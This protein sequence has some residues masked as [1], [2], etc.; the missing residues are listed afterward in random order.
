MVVLID[1]KKVSMRIR[2]EIKKEVV[3]LKEKGINP[4]LS[5]VLVGSDMASR[6]YVNNKKKACA[7]VGML[8]KE[9]LLPD[10]ASEEELLE[11]IDRL[12]KDKEVHGILVQLPLPKHIDEMKVIEAIDP[13][14]DVD[15]FHPYNVGRL[16]TGSGIFA[17][18]T[19]AGV[20]ELIKE[21]GTEIE[22]K[23]CVVVGR[24]N[25]VGKPMA[26]LLLAANGTVTVTH[27]RTKDLKSV[28]KRADILIFAIGKA[29]FVNEEYVKPGAVVIDVGMNRDENNKLCG[30]VD[31]ERVKDICGAITPVPGGVGPMTI[32]TLLSNTLL[33]ARMFG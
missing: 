20:M 1:G 32:T 31:F 21:T 30:D 8:S 26:M 11:L 15:C 9:F 23:E 16:Y 6:T 24:S 29:K 19:P 2:E 7:E 18:C 27:S 3:E 12:N 25:I 22:G 17:P 13:K 5:V 33:A 4:C 14:K 28:C 10:E